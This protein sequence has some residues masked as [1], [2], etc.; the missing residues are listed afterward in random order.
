MKKY[1][2][3]VILIVTF[4]FTTLLISVS[5]ASPITAGN[6][7]LTPESG[8]YQNNVDYKFTTNAQG[9][10]IIEI[11][12]NKKVTISGTT[13]KEQIII[14]SDANIIIENLSIDMYKLNVPKDNYSK[15]YPPIVIEQG[16]TTITL[17]GKNTLKQSGYSTSLK[18]SENTYLTIEGDG[19]LV[20]YTS[21]HGSAIGSGIQEYAGHITI[22]SG[23]ID[24]KQFP[25][26]ESN[27][28]FGSVYSTG[29]GSGDFGIN[30]TNNNLPTRKTVQSITINGGLI[31]AQTDFAP[32]IGGGSA[33]IVG[34]IKINGGEIQAYLTSLN[35]TSSV[36]GS[37]QIGEVESIDIT[38][39]KI[40]AGGTFFISRYD[41]NPRAHGIG[42]AANSYENI[43]TN[44]TA[45]VV[46]ITGMPIIFTSSIFS[47]EYVGN[48][49]NPRNYNNNQKRKDWTGYIFEGN[50]GLIYPETKTDNFKLPNDFEIPWD[51][52]SIYSNSW[53]LHIPGPNQTTVKS[54]VAKGR[55][56]ASLALD[57]VVHDKVVRKLTIPKGI[58]FKNDGLIEVHEG[59]VIVNNGTLTEA[60]YD[61]REKGIINKGI[62][63]SVHPITKKTRKRYKRYDNKP[64]W[65]YPPEIEFLILPADKNDAEIVGNRYGYIKYDETLNHYKDYIPK[66]NALG[67]KELKAGWYQVIDGVVQDTPF[68]PTKEIYEDIKLTVKF[69][70]ISDPP[71]IDTIVV[72]D[73]NITGIGI[74]DSTVKVIFPDGSTK[75]T[76]VD[77]NNKWS[78]IVEDNIT[79]T[80]NDTIK[81]TQT[82]IGK[83]ESIEATKVPID[84]SKTPVFD[85]IHVGD[86]KI[87]GTGIKGSTVEVT[88]PDNSKATAIVDEN[89][90]WTVDVPAGMYL[91]ITD[92]LKAT[93][94]EVGK[95][96]SDEVTKDPI[97]KSKPPV[98][99]TIYV[100]DKKITGTGIKQSKVKIIFPNGT[101]KEVIVDENNKWS[102]TVDDNITLKVTDTLKATQT[103]IGKTISDETKINPIKRVSNDP[104]K[105]KDPETPADPKPETPKDNNL[106]RT[107]ST[108]NVYLYLL[109][110]S[111]ILV[112]LLGLRVIKK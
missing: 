33:S 110:I 25:G 42:R 37:G 13:N 7:T 93:Q 109:S 18:V 29:I 6:L 30:A 57:L 48:I 11:L 79:L 44:N 9:P 52:P 56:S 90:K 89:N 81:A 78:V 64:N 83:S 39:G 55:L 73:K 88:F 46:N 76:I 36:I 105:P 67:T 45:P 40:L 72:G 32:A 20:A 102:V 70:E 101:I 69:K 2:N 74:K 112:G 12:S 96:I 50:S 51:A 100:G 5:F 68:D 54:F 8:T 61:L 103:E 65:Y 24:I 41:Q 31:K 23:T 21:G 85:T 99:D 19:E 4:L 60:K 106:P 80:I 49:K 82:E 77:K 47:D 66:V 95:A 92:T 86:K 91:T 84:K 111:F 75:T 38:G 98:F 58:T 28:T 62:I 108:T 104:V 94:T 35:S 16:K 26:N 87:T 34:P 27:G 107:G 17:K 10:N 14:K 59:G 43:Y 71:V 63:S 3:K 22:N 1:I 53:T 97:G 15:K